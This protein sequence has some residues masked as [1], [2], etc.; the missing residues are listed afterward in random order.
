MLATSA[1]AAPK[2]K[3]SE[4][5]TPAKLE[6]PCLD[7]KACKRHA[8]DAF[9]AALA[10]QRGGKADRPL[11]VS[12]FGDSITADDHIT[13]ALRRKLQA[14]VGDGGAGF[15]FAAPPHPYCQHRRI[16]RLISDD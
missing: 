4:S 8:L 2:A 12:Y 16:T 13:D 14:L 7:G 3:Q 10:V 15:V 9:R 5:V 11:R 6:E 1:L